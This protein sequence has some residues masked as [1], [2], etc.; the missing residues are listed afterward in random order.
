MIV[1]PLTRIPS[2]P[3]NLPLIARAAV[4]VEVTVHFEAM[5]MLQAISVFAKRGESLESIQTKIFNAYWDLPHKTA[6]HGSPTQMHL[7]SQ[8]WKAIHGHQEFWERCGR[9]EH[10]CCQIRV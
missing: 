2:P 8:D 9:R 4:P 7:L 6:K 10:F 1:S 3:L 5:K